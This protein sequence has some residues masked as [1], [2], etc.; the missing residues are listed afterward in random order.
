[1][2]EYKNHLDTP[3]P[4]TI[5]LPSA[6]WGA[7]KDKA[8]RRGVSMAVFVRQAVDDELAKMVEDLTELGVTHETLPDKV[9]R[10][11]FHSRTH[12]LLADHAAT[13]GLPQVRLLALC[14]HRHVNRRRRRPRKSRNR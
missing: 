2:A 6:L 12:Q 4:R 3:Q 11:P 14:L 13:T 10:V 1:M 8:A 5:K 7:A 9:I